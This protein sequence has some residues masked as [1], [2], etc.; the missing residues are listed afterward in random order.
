MELVELLLPFI[1]AQDMPELVGCDR[2][3]RTPDYWLGW[4]LGYFQMQTAVPYRRAFRA[5]PYREP[6]TMYH[7]LHEAPESKFVEALNDRLFPQT[8]RR[9][10]NSD[11]DVVSDRPLDDAQPIA[12]SEKR[13]FRTGTS[14]GCL[15]EAAGL[16]QS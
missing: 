5:A 13:A 2:F 1:G 10:R 6:V 7:P 4:V 14:L 12:T 9:V 16:S 8:Q 3:D 11:K 15:R